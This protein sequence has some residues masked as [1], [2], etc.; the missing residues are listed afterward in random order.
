[1][2]HR[3]EVRDRIQQLDPKADYHEIV[4]LGRLV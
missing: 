1:M 4:L 2:G 3:F